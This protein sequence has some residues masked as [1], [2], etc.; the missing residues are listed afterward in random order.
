MSWVAAGRELSAQDLA[1]LGLQDLAYIRSVLHK[2]EPA[3]A[4]YAADGTL[5]ALSASRAAAETL[6]RQND[7]E[8]VSVH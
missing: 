4:V 2:G 3:F 1:V 7:M 8:P 6:I 5:M